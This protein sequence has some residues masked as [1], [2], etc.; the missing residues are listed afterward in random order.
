MV[1]KTY[2]QYIPQTVLVTTYIIIPQHIFTER[3]DIFPRHIHSVTS[4]HI[5]NTYVQDILR[6]IHIWVY[7]K[8]YNMVLKT[9]AQCIPQTVLVT[10]YIIIS[11]HIFTDR[12]HIPSR[13]IRQDIWCDAQ[14]ICHNVSTHMICVSRHILKT[15]AFN[16]YHQDIYFISIHIG[17]SQDISSGHMRFKTYLQHIFC[18]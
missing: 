3:Q 9:Y 16:T 11:Q 13:H 10:T 2:P 1:L 14:D 7:L 12:Q 4:W 6:S 8:T 15:Y 17:C 5:L 18:G